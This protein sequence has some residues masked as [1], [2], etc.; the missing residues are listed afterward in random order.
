MLF[1]NRVIG[2]ALEVHRILGPGLLESAYE[3][4]F[5]QELRLIGLDFEA[6]RTLPIFYKGT[7]LECGYRIDFLI[8]GQLIVELK[9]V[10]QVLPIH[11]A[12]LISYMKLARVKTG[13]LIDFNVPLLKDGIRRFVL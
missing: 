4:C 12:Q 3:H 10:P 13:L 5:A 7:R 2:A 9:T 1:S 6:E 11:R 8:E